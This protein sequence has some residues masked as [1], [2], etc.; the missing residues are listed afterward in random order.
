MQ[1][2]QFILNL[3]TLLEYIYVLVKNI[4]KK[5]L[6]SKKHICGNRTLQ[7]QNF[8]KDVQ[9]QTLLESVGHIT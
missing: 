4:Q 7:S 1:K 3:K 6:V 5:A 2:W 9:T 8:E